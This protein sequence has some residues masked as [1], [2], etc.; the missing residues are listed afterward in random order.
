M[1][2]VDTKLTMDR[3]GDLTVQTF[4]DVQ[5]NADWAAHCRDT[6]QHGKDLRHKW[7]LPNNMINKFYLDYAGPVGAPP[8]MNQEFWV[9]VDK[10][11]NDPQ[12]SKFRT[13]NPSNPFFLGHRKAK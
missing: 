7:H 1:A 2:G 12:Y 13:D 6:Q 10:R 4:Q 8:P 9:Y 3:K 5:I 11:M